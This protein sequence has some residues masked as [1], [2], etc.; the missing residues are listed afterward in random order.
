[1]LIKNKTCNDLYK[2]QDKFITIKEFGNRKK[3]RFYEMIQNW[4]NS[5]EKFN[6]NIKWVIDNAVGPIANRLDST[7]GVWVRGNVIPYRYGNVGQ[8]I[9][10][11]AGNI[12]L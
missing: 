12:I 1:M 8:N 9:I 6:D 5:I 11:G 10:I 2:I 4:N 7:H 3:F